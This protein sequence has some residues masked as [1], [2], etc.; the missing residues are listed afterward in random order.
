V[1]EATQRGLAPSQILVFIPLLIP[2]TLPYT[3]PATTLFATCYVYG[4]LSADNEITALRASGV[5]L[6]RVILPCLLLGAATSTVTMALYYEPIPRTHQTM[7]RQVQKDLQTWLYSVLRRER[8]L[9]RPE[10]DFVLFVKEVRGERLVDAIFKQ[11]DKSDKKPG[12]VNYKTVARAREAEITVDLPNRRIAVDMEH[13]VIFDDKTIEGVIAHKRFE[14]E[15]PPNL[16]VEPPRRP[17]D[18]TWEEILQRQGT[19]AEELQTT[20]AEMNSLLSRPPSAV[21]A[22]ALH[23]KEQAQFYTLKAK[24]QRTEMRQ[25]KAELLIRPAM[26]LGCLCFVAVGCPVGIWL[27]KSDY[28]SSFVSCFLPTVFAYYPLMLCGG[29]L[30]KDGKIPAAV[31]IFAADAVMAVAAVVLTWRL[32]RK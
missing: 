6:L 7:K 15:L 27:S 17:V 29:N 18:L 21:P 26:A 12:V 13:C 2:N 1:A 14:V 23:D 30:A 28:L 3:I 31:G 9:R 5:H 20:D 22:T 10:L 8:C 11:R 25:L 19:L 24:L 32:L 16:L 4:R